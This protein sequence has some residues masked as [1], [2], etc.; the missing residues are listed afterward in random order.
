MENN[1]DRLAQPRVTTDLQFVLKKKKN[2]V[3]TKPKKMRRACKARTALK[4][5]AVGKQGMAQNAQ[6]AELGDCGPLWVSCDEH[7]QVRV[8]S[9]STHTAR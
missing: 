5:R 8:R 1:A 4:E 7:I 6:N 9:W 3:S 2:A